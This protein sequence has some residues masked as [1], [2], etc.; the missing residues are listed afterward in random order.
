MGTTGILTDCSVNNA[1]LGLVVVFSLS[2]DFALHCE[3]P[4]L[5]ERPPFRV[6]RGEFYGELLSN[7][8]APVLQDRQ[9]QENHRVYGQRAFCP[10]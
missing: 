3:P 9:L 4:S 10:A 2:G 6:I 7:L 5:L 8:R 1:T